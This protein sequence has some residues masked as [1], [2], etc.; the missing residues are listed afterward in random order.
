[1][2]DEPV[3]D[4]VTFGETM[5]RLAVPDHGRLAQ[6]HSFDVSIGGTESN[7]AVALAHLGRR[8]RWV[9][10]LPDNPLG[11]RIAADLQREGVDVSAVLWRANVR[12]GVYFLELGS[13]PR[14]TRVIYDRGGS[15]VA[16]LDPTAVDPRLVEEGRVVHLTGI[17]PALS[18]SCAKICLRLAD[19]AEESDRPL[20]LDVNYRALLWS[21]AEARAGL[22]HL[23]QRAT[24]LFCGA[25]DA[26]TI[27]GLSGEPR[28]IAAGLLERSAAE[29]VILTLGARGAVT[30]DRANRFTEQA[31][32]QVDIVDPVGAGD[33][34]AAG[35][36]HRWLDDPA[37]HAAALRSGV[38]L[39]SLAMTLRGDL[40][41][42][43]VDE[44]AQV[45]AQM[46]GAGTDI[47]R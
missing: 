22:T 16:E 11:Q 36:L 30:L 38:A 26:E 39:A 34:L 6:A 9:S 2:T 32:S 19:A 14:P 47:L 18:E 23:L 43:T 4:A 31:A 25:G 24:L 33:A 21:P 13:A 29:L 10:A 44:L 28:E 20:S 40:T 45:E 12:V 41:T 8:V 5:L 1:M 17:T 3:Y 37:D 7:L 15:A 27:W 35:F 46:S 42:V